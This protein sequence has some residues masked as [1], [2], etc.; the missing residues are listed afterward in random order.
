MNL[1][2]KMN[3][4][5]VEN[6]EEKL[7][8]ENKKIPQQIYEDEYSGLSFKIPEGFEI[9]KVTGGIYY[10]GEKISP[11]TILITGIIN[12][13]DDD[14][15]KLKIQLL[16]RGTIKEGI[17]SKNLVYGSPI[18]ELSRFGIPIN[19]TNFKIIVKYL[20]ELE[21]ENENSIPVI[22]AVSK[23]GWRDG[24][25]IPFSKDSD[26]VI[27]VDYK[28]QKWV[29]AY[30]FKGNLE[31]WIKDIKPFRKNPIFRFVLSAFFAAPLLRLIGHRI[32]I[33]YIWGNSRARKVGSIKSWSWYL[34][35]SKRTYFN[36]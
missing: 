36:I 4:E 27:D 24:Y 17:F 30:T 2:N 31:D 29:N 13:L 35:K 7:I 21:A 25:F 12:N 18:N 6:V 1:K 22:K 32:F 5:I 15:E 11:N 16:K 3:E 9:D 33:V 28:L 26:I 14:T 20:A 8:E 34:G 10:N 19:I 23:L